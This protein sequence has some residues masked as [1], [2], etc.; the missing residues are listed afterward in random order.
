MKTHFIARHWPKTLETEHGET[1]EVQN[2]VTEDI[3]MSTQCMETG[4]HED[5]EDGMEVDE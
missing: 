5:N 1:K 2:M 4:E 3:E